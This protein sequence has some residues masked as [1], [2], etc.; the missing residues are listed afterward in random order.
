MLN[1]F[2]NSLSLWDGGLYIPI[3]SH[4]HLRSSNGSNGK[5]SCLT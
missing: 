4:L 3:K 5:E 2:V 1:L